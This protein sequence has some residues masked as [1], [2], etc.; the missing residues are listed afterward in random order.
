MKQRIKDGFSY[1]IY[2]LAAEYIVLAV[3]GLAILI[4]RFFVQDYWYISLFLGSNI[5]SCTA[6][7]VFCK[8]IG[9]READEGYKFKLTDTVPMLIGIAVYVFLT[10]ITGYKVN[11]AQTNSFFL[12]HIFVG[13]YDL[14]LQELIDH[15]SNLLFLGVAINTLIK[16]PF[17]VLGYGN[18]VKKRVSDRQKLFSGEK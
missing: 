10:V 11:W 8:K 14:G 2:V 15:H 18:G 1:F 17:M 16:Y 12:T 6:V 13:R 9:Y 5:A 7:F 4:T 3:G